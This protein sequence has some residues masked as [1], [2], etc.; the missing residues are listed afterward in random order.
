MRRMIWTMGVALAIAAPA[1]AQPELVNYQG[2]VNDANGQPLA[3]ATYTMSFSIFSTVSGG[4]AAWGP[5]LFD[6]GSGDGHGPLV[7]VKDGRYNV[8]LGPMDT[9]GRSIV[10]AFEGTGDRY[11]EIAVGNNTITPRQQFLSV[12]YAFRAINSQT[13]NLGELEARVAALENLAFPPGTA[14]WSKRFGASSY[15]LAK[16][17]TYDASGNLYLAGSTNSGGFGFGN[18]LMPSGSG[19]IY[20][21]K[22]T[23]QGAYV[24]DIHFAYNFPH[25]I[26][27]VAADSKGDVIIVG[28]IGEPVDF[29][30]GPLDHTQFGTDI[31]VAKFS[32]VDGDHLWSASFPADDNDAA[33]AVAV[34]ANDDFIVGARFR[35]E[36][37]TIGSDFFQNKGREDMLLFKL[38]GATG[39]PVWARSWGGLQDDNIADIAL[40][41]N[42][43]IA[44]TGTIEGAVTISPTITLMHHGIIS[45]ANPQRLFTM[46]CNSLG[47]PQWGKGYT[48]NAD[49]NTFDEIAGGCTV[50]EDG[51]MWMVGRFYT[52]VDFGGG[53]IGELNRNNIGFIKYRLSDGAHLYSSALNNAFAS[54]LHAVFP[55]K[56]EI[57][58]TGRVGNDYNFGG[59]LLNFGMFLVKYH[60][61]DA[62]LVHDWSHGFGNSGTPNDIAA[63]RNNAALCGTFTGALDLGNGPFTQ[64]GTNDI[65]VG[66]FKQ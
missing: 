3:S 61:D 66:V 60:L 12:P 33:T 48:P 39:E 23:G 9:A 58:I 41:A 37:A 56:D 50:D 32:G 42:N 18:G 55:K 14:I 47:V 49:R 7:L 11:L 5:F 8:I 4:A 6:G 29:G 27:D 28:S 30:G 31:F 36:F 21:A 25:E 10:T 65:F 1:M 34:D 53:K 62:T 46:G 40:D 19:R 51:N 54:D 57:I 26:L 17:C 16:A 64:V 52:S 43:N 35:G 44:L 15:E 20:L 13:A 63:S 22:L 24:W 59:A 38:A 45:N 2:L